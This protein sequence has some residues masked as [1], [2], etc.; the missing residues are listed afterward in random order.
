MIS[1]RILGNPAV[2]MLIAQEG[3]TFSRLSTAQSVDLFGGMACFIGLQENVE[4]LAKLYSGR[5]GEGTPLPAD[6]DFHR[7]V[8]QNLGYSDEAIDDFLA[9]IELNQSIPLQ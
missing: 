4:N 3:D 5:G 8:G 2:R 9:R 1:P 6:A 7:A